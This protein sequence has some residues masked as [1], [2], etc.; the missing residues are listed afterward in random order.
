MPQSPTTSAAS[1][2]RRGAPGIN[3]LL[4]HVLATG[5]MTDVQFTVGRQHGAAKIFQAH[6][7][8]LCLNSDVF[9]AMF[10]GGLPESREEPIDVMEVLPEAFSIMLGFMYTG[11]ARGSLRVENVFQVI[12]CADK[13]NLPFLMEKCLEFVRSHLNADNCLVYLEN[14]KPFK[15][16]SVAACV[17]K[18]LAVVDA[19]TD[20]IFHSKQFM[21]ISQDT[22][23]LVLQRNALSADENSIYTAVE[24]WSVEACRKN[25]L[26]PSSGN[27]RQMLGAVLS[28]IRFPLLT[29]SQLVNG[30]DKSELLT[31]IELLAIYKYKHANVKP[32][33]GFPVEPRM[34]TGFIDFQCKE[35]VFVRAGNTGWLPGEISDR[36]GNGITVNIQAK[37]VTVYAPD[38][39]VRASDILKK[40][41]MII[42]WRNCCFNSAE[43]CGLAA[44]SGRHIVHV[45]DGNVEVDF[46]DLVISR[47]QMTLWKVAK[48]G[49]LGGYV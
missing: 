35:L 7:F 11:S 39:I 42:A 38:Q 31:E 18:C 16:D 28:L 44:A 34:C 5:Q 12:Y 41:Q 46:M 33:L 43:Y 24:E 8:I 36:N 30:P 3:N 9:D 22:L 21:A 10:N 15:H 27:R 40:H 25:N 49:G 4:K 23:G 14:V 1:D 48:S 26:K 37:S 47:N 19:S 6:K 29:D 20:A 32:P 17:E 45:A 2:W 13:Y